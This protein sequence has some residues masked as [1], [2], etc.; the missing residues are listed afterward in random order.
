MTSYKPTGIDFKAITDKCVELMEEDNTSFMG[1]LW[2]DKSGRFSPFNLATQAEY[3]GC[4]IINLWIEGHVNGFSSMGWMTLLQA[5]QIGAK[6]LTLPNDHPG[7]GD[8]KTGQKGTPVYNAGKFVPKD[9]YSRQ[10]S[11][12]LDLKEGVLVGLEKAQRQY[13]RVAGHVFNLEQFDPE[14]I[15]E[16]YRPKPFVPA[17]KTEIEKVFKQFECKEE[18]SVDNR[19]F[20]KPS[21][22]TVHMVAKDCFTS[23]D[24]WIHVRSHEYVHATGHPT[25]L[26]RFKV[27]ET[28]DQAQYAYEELIAE[29]G[30]AFMCASFGIA[31]TWRHAEYL[32]HY[33]AV[34]K[35]DEKALFHAAADAQ[36]AV[37]LLLNKQ[38]QQEIA[39]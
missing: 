28:R 37:E 33:L 23:E 6:L 31:V 38:T 17:S 26:N 1:A 19:C 8:S 36:K 4:N 3:K 35:A 21:T 11:H 10:G 16:E 34:L 15:P 13:L 27:G 32:K 2:N 25:Y 30:S 29:M 9:R 22:H 39:A 12:Y 7:R 24:D 18:V 14:T 5:K 20:Y